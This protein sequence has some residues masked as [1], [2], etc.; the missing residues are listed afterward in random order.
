MFAGYVTANRSVTSC[1]EDDIWSPPLADMS[2]T[3][4]IALIVGSEQ[5]PSYYRSV[6]VYAEDFNLQL[7]DIGKD[8]KRSSLDYVNGKAVACQHDFCL[9]LDTS[10]NIII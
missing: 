8:M 7:P 5:G 2:C 4:G 10:G 9:Q 1:A 6:E 3:E